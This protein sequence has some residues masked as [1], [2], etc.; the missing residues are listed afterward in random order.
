MEQPK[1]ENIFLKYLK[2]PGMW[3]NAMLGKPNPVSIPEHQVTYQTPETPPS[4]TAIQTPPVNPVEQT[5]TPTASQTASTGGEGDSIMNDMKIFKGVADKVAA[6]VIEVASPV[7][8]KGLE[9]SAEAATAT[10]AFAKTDKFKK[11][12]PMILFVFVLLVVGVV[13]FTVFKNLS[14]KADP[15][16]VNGPTPTAADYYPTVPSLY[17]DDEE[18]LKLEETINQLDREIAGTQLRETTLNPPVLDFNIN[19]N[20]R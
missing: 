5:Q 19:F 14:K 18:V 1:K 2:H 17:A 20:S 13:G 6:K 4:T 10:Q 11:I 3:V 15:V 12:L 8:S 9:T 16:V 7:V